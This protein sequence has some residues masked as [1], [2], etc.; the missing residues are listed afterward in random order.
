MAKVIVDRVGRD[1]VITMIAM[2]HTLVVEGEP[3][4]YRY[5]NGLTHDEVVTTLERVAKSSADWNAYDNCY[6]M[7]QEM[8]VHF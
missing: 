4:D 6:A 1:A 3:I 5:A 7:L 8:I 2:G